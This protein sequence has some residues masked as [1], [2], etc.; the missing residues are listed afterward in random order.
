MWYTAEFRGSRFSIK[1]HCI[2]PSAGLWIF[3]CSHS[4]LQLFSLSES[5][6]LS[7]FVRRIIIFC[8]VR[9]KVTPLDAGTVGRRKY[10]S[11]PFAASALECG[12]WSTPLSAA[13]PQGKTRFSVTYVVGSKSSRPD[14]LCYF[15]T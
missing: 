12:A 6:N 15:S 13:L 3:Y 2:L 8:D 14:Q 11:N 4:K 9:V 5:I 1:N 10:S 7:T